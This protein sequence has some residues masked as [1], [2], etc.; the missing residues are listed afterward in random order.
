[1]G[2]QS[3]PQLQLKIKNI[4]PREYEMNGVDKILEQNAIL[5]EDQI[6]E[7]SDGFINF[8]TNPKIK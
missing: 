2:A 4:S 1:M 6:Y 3:N 5:A 8:L 7:F